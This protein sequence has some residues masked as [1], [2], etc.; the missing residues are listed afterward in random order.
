MHTAY[1]LYAMHTIRIVRTAV[2]CNAYSLVNLYPAPPLQIKMVR[3]LRY[4]SLAIETL[5]NADQGGLGL[6]NRECQPDI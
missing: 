3:G 2:G 4:V 6:G 5:K 1:S